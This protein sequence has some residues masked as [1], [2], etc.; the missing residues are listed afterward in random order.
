MNARQLL[1]NQLQIVHNRLTGLADMTR[2]EWLSRP[3]PEN[4]RAGF[5]AWHMVATRDWAVRAILGA[6]RPIGWDAPFAGTGVALCEIPF[7]MPLA[8]ADAIA[9]ATT[10]GEVIAYSAAV[11]DEIRRWLEAATDE[12][13]DNPPARARDH[14]ALSPRYSERDYRWELE[15]NPADMCLWPVW[16]L[17]T[18]PSFTHCIGHLA[19]IDIARERRRR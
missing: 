7:S 14:I 8:E 3:E 16:A 9:D 2:E 17:L 13:L 5:L 4:N 1:A 6:Q 18:R 10:P 12:D 19:E 15:E 11:D